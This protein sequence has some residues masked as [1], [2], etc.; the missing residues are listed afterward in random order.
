M[1]Y[2]KIRRREKEID[3]LTKT[4]TLIHHHHDADD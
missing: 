1:K 4:L 2:E 3:S